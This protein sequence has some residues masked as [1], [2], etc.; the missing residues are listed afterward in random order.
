MNSGSATSY[1][2]VAEITGHDGPVRAI[3]VGS[4]GQVISGSQDST[5][6]FWNEIPREIHRDTMD[7]EVS[8][9][10]AEAGV[11][12]D[13]DH[14]VTAL[15]KLPPDV[16]P[17]C[18][19]GGVISGSLDKLIRIFTNEGALVRVLSGHTG[20]VI[21]LGWT[22]NNMLLSGSWDGSAKIWDIL[23]GTCVQTFGE[24]ENGVCVLGLPNAQI[25]TGSTGVKDDQDKVVGCKIRIF[26]QE[27]PGCV[28]LT[29]HDGPVRHL[30]LVGD[31]GFA[32][33]SNDGTVHFRTYQ[34]D[35]FA[36]L[37][38][39]PNMEGHPTFILQGAALADGAGF[40]SVGDDGPTGSCMVWSLDG[41]LQ[42]SLPHPSGVW[43]VAALPNGDFVTGCQDNK[44]RIFTS[45]ESRMGPETLMVQFCL[46]YEEALKKGQKGPSSDEVA[47]LPHW[48]NRHE[49]KGN[50]Q[51]MVALFQKD[52][53]AIA[54]EWTAVSGSWVEIGEVTG[55]AN[56]GTIDGVVYDH[57]FPIEIEQATGEVAKLEIGYNNGQNPFNCAQDFIDKNMLPQS[58]LGQISDYISQR[59]RQSAPTL[60]NFG[61]TMASGAGTF[62]GVGVPGGSQFAR[63]SVVP[64][65]QE[66]R[67]FPERAYFLYDAVQLSKA[68]QKV[69]EFNEGL[70]EGIALTAKEAQHISQLIKTLNATSHYHSSSVHDQEFNAVVKILKHWPIEKV[71]PAIDI[72]RVVVL[73]SDGGVKIGNQQ[74]FPHLMTLLIQKMAEGK[75]QV[76]I[77]LL[78]VRFFCNALKN[79]SCRSNILQNLSS[80]L[81]SLSDLVNSTN[82]T[83]RSAT[84][85]CVL[86]CTVAMT[87][88]SQLG[89][90]GTQILTTIQLG[91]ANYSEEESALKLLVALG[92]ILHVFPSAAKETIKDLELD[93][94]VQSLGR[95]TGTSIPISECIE[96][97]LHALNC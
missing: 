50:K 96:D 43:C 93:A 8:I 22:L 36:V 24:H 60:G 6:R 13:H 38:H 15:I 52:G 70:S 9:N 95:S 34:G 77:P 85:A 65:R 45:D 68:E 48:E 91:L 73:H 14:W 40:V 72:L 71:F 12:F 92:T 44:I 89:A 20:G 80:L 94:L 79:A 51:G 28:V 47:K 87:E 37:Q 7:E 53:K 74:T 81:D 18:P 21:S 26:P 49:R 64:S 19:F 35:T 17:E 66:A 75:A 55:S 29:D 42:Q 86:N 30:S 10:Y 83:I 39:P 2:L 69:L 11:I 1:K 84:A 23:T 5:V 57:V 32:S 67:H 54:A 90:E 88:K 31:L 27:V 46:E 58:Y 61:T 63:Q 25:A 59:A 97:I 41:T 3:C 56:A 16:I 82:K 33:T 78:V 4:E 62:T 76:A